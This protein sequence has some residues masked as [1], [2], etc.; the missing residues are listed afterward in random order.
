MERSERIWSGDWRSR[1]ETR[2]RAAGFSNVGDF[3]AN[4]PA[5]PYLMLA[6]KLGDDVAAIQLEWIQWANLRTEKEIR[7][8]AIDSL[9]RAVVGHLPAGWPANPKGD[10]KVACAYSE[11]ITRIEQQSPSL[12][13]K[14]KAVWEQ[15][16]ALDPPRGW[17]PSGPDDRY[18]VHAFISG[19][20]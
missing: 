9:P 2:V 7:N 5:E 4:F 6:K 20:P 10:F 12:K 18:V 15:L 16:K 13:P 17:R 8:L 19:W 3:L 14:A 1:V 11:W